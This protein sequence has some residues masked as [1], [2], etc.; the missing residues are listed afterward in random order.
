M[1]KLYITPENKQGDYMRTWFQL[2]V[3]DIK[4]RIP[5]HLPYTLKTK[6]RSFERAV[7]VAKRN[8]KENRDVVLVELCEHGMVHTIEYSHDG[9]MCMTECNETLAHMVKE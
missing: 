4:D 5:R 1:K 7:A 2:V 8:V 6:F 9:R 3:S